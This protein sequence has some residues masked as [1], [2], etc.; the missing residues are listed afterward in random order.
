MF[1]KLAPCILSPGKS[2]SG[3]SDPGKLGP[4]KMLVRQIGPRKVWQQKSQIQ[5]LG[6]NG[7]RIAVRHLLFIFIHHHN[8]EHV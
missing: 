4:W 8:D 1:E 6:K 5:L 7:T 2:G 3:K